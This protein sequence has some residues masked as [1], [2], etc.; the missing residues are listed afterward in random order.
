MWYAAYPSATKGLSMYG[1]CSTSTATLRDGE[2]PIRMP[3][4]LAL[5]RLGVYG[6]HGVFDLPPDAVLYLGREV[7][8][9]LD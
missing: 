4:R 3:I 8:D 7:V 6:Y 9:A 5:V 1:K 2:I